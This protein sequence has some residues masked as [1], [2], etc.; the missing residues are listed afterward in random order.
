MELWEL[1]IRELVRDTVAAYAH[2]ADGGRFHDLVALFT[3]DG[4]LEID[5]ED[6]YEGRDAI[7]AFL[8]AVGADLKDASAVPFIRHFTSNLHIEVDDH[9]SARARCYFLAVTAS[10]LDHWGRYRDRLVREGDRFL[11]SHRRVRT[12]GGVPGSF[13]EARKRH[14][15]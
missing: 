9:D 2:A 15:V 7:H 12:D 5:G 4:I 14:E 11:F 13:A 8:T 1:D 3:P 6:A 10:G